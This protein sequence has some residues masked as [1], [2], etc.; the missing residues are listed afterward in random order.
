MAVKRL[1]ENDLPALKDIIVETRGKYPVSSNSHKI[2]PCLLQR[3]EAR[4]FQSIGARMVLADVTPVIFIHDA[5]V[6]MEGEHVD[7][8]STIINDV[9]KELGLNPPKLNQKKWAEE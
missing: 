7:K 4:T 3:V 5:V 2:L 9:F 8:A 1:N 6:V